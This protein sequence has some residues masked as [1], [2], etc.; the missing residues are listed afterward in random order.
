MAL[1]KF[2][3]QPGEIKD[4]DVTFGPFLDAHADT[5]QAGNPI[6]TG[7]VPA[8]ITL[9]TVVWVPEI[10]TMKFWVSGGTSGQKYTLTASL[11]TAGGRRL[12]ADI[13]VA[14]KEQI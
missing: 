3:K 2:T 13:Q 12:E 10:R 6:V 7:A 14:V 11:L 9:V 8:G 5:A 1:E 4:F